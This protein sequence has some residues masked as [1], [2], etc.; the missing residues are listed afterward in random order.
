MS[1]N[2]RKR[3]TAWLRW[4]DPGVGP[5][6]VGLTWS[7][8]QEGRAVLVGFELWSRPPGNERLSP[9]PVAE[10]WDELNVGLS[11]PPKFGA[12]VLHDFPLMS[13]AKNTRRQLLE[14]AEA[15]AARR[16]DAGEEPLDGFA[17]GL[18][19]TRQG[20]YGP[21]HFA[22][23]ADV[24]TEALTQGLDPY[25]EIRKRWPASKSTIAKWI[26]RARHDFELLPPTTRGRTASFGPS[27]ELPQRQA[28][29]RGKGT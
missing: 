3:W 16:R 5:W 22:A 8:T 9:G 10:F 11:E 28:L 26:S 25:S 24:Y 15:E 29:A 14:T 23:V 18:S 1:F 4:P 21:E 27:E 12:K 20:R 7:G 19:T 13:V 2:P 6:H 17:E